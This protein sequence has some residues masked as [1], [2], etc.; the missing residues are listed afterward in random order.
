MGPREVALHAS[1]CPHNRYPRRFHSVQECRRY[2][3]GP[4]QTDNC[5]NVSLQRAVRVCEIRE[6]RKMWSEK[7]GSCGQTS[8]FEKLF[9]LKTQHRLENAVCGLVPGPIVP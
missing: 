8:I 9:Q 1:V 2:R 5:S 7:L 3:R 6:W 4:T